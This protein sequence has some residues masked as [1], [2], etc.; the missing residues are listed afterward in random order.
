MVFQY[1]GVFMTS[2]QQKIVDF[3][4]ANPSPPDTAV[5]AFAD[6]EGVEHSIVEGEIYNLL[7]SLLNGV[8]KHNDTP[9]S[10]FD[11]QELAAGIEVEKEHTDSEVVAR[12]IA[13]DHLTEITDYYTRL[14]AMEEAAKGRDIVSNVVSSL[15]NTVFASVA[16]KDLLS[17]LV[18]RV[19]K[20]SRNGLY[21]EH[22]D[23]DAYIDGMELLDSILEPLVEDYDIGKQTTDLYMSEDILQEFSDCFGPGSSIEEMCAEFESDP[24][25][26]LSGMKSSLGAG[27]DPY[28]LISRS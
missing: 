27:I 26:V 23:G 2:L 9:D 24:I 12:M 1:M 16:T 7:S 19:K 13:K 11:P 6:T 8:G 20:F 22:E 15:T 21:F 10:E 3:F 28:D 5:H 4:V 17:G 18:G 14:K 25:G